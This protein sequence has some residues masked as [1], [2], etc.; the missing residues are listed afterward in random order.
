MN[1]SDKPDL[2]RGWL[3]AEKLFED[4]AERLATMSDEDFE[5]EMNAL[6]DLWVAVG[7]EAPAAPADVGGGKP[8]AVVVPMGVGK[9]RTRTAT[10]WI[11]LL[12]AAALC[13]LVFF[14]ATRPPVTVASSDGRVRAEVLRAEA[15]EACAR[16]SYTTCKRDLDVART[17]DPAGDA[18]A[19][20]QAARAAVTEGLRWETA[21]GEGGGGRRGE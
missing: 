2:A 16:M 9:T 11:A 10:R 4:E 19:R 18:D 8:V 13:A 5:R 20:V 21:P 12:A 17:L 7:A 15:Y 1:P 14:V 3:H 6:P